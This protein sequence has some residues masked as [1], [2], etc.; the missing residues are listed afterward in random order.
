MGQS[1]VLFGAVKNGR[2]LAI[3]LPPDPPEAS[4]ATAPKLLLKRGGQPL[5]V[6]V[7][8]ESR[9]NTPWEV[10]VHMPAGSGDGATLYWQDVHRAP[11]TANPVLVD[12]QTGERRSLRTTS[13]HSFAVSRE[14]GVYRFRME[15]VPLSGLLRLT[16]V[17]VSGGRSAGGQYTLSFS[18]NTEAQVEAN[19]YAGG[20]LIRRLASG[21]SRSAGIHQVT[22]DGRDA[23][24][25]V[26]PAG[27]YLVEVKA[28]SVDGQVARVVVPITLTR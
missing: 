15:M 20:K 18:L 24:G 3:G 21:S 27:S 12:L 16:Q 17:R 4:T 14:G 9:L 13:S 26:L 2:G 11:C 6:D 28:V 25:I 19:V 10:E 1:E 5:S 8:A 7:R 23:N 22:W